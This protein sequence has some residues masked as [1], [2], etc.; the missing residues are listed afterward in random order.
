MILNEKTLR[1]IIREELALALTRTLLVETGPK[2]Q[3]DP[4][5]KVTK[6]IN[7]NMLDFWTEY[8]PKIEGALRGMQEDV[9]HTKNRVVEQSEKISAIGSVLIDM[10]SS[11]LKLAMASD[12]LKLSNYQTTLIENKK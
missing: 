5:G 8:A 3:G 9:D 1:K 7:I 11:A 12:S 10:E 2:N 6:E 4:E